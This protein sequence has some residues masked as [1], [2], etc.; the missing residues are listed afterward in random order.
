MSITPE[1]TPATATATTPTRMSPKVVTTLSIGTTVEWF[2]FA[3]Y[4]F[5]ATAIAA[6]FFPDGNA[7]AAFLQTL[8]VYAVAY[9]VRP[10]GGLVFG[11]IGDKIG[12]RAAL[13]LALTLMGL[14]TAGIGL[15]P[16][17]A[18]IGIAAPILLIVC[19]LIG[20]FSASSEL[21]GAT[22][23]AAETAP[24]GRR[25]LWINF[26]SCFGSVGSGLATVLVLA[27]QVNAE[28]YAAGSWR[29]PFIIGGIIALGGLLLRLTMSETAVHTEVKNDPNSRIPS[30]G[31][32]LRG[33]WRAILVAFCFYV[34]V[35]IGFQT[36]LGYMPSYMKQVGKVSADSALVI[37]LIAFGCFALFVTLYG[38]LSDRI[39]RKPL[40]VYGTIAVAVLSV[41][42]YLMI[43]SGNIVLVC[44]AQILLVVSLAA[45]QAGGNAIVIERF[46]AGLRF[47]AAAISYTFAYASFAGT[48]P[49]VQALL[50]GVGGNIMPAVY[51]VA[52]AILVLPVL[53]KGFPETRHFDI[54]T[55]RLAK[56]PS[57]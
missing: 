4:G 18:T 44:L 40:I 5:S 13:T 30:F 41:P 32:M 52:I 9:V 42:A 53:A 33:H 21:T 29:W 27:F 34:L 15:I 47:S 6:T 38:A 25:G 46:P 19:R 39:G 45:V 1:Q 24:P 28:A 17:Y 10:L 31:E 55:G 16:S 2:D 7:T 8:A 43:M 37:S 14:S 3:L 36:L 12:R 57:A 49:L 51:G 48:A 56:E 22:T 23:F 35:G 20:G 11:R 50:V 54:K 26:V